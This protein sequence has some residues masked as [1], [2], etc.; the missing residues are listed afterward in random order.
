MSTRHL[1]A[2]GVIFLVVAVFA[3]LAVRAAR[4]RRP[5]RD[6]LR[7]DLFAAEAPDDRDRQP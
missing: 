6:H 3:L 4:R 5:A 2:W 7:V 1:I